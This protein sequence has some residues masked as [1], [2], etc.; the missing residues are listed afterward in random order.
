[1]NGA[2]L[3]AVPLEARRLAAAALSVWSQGDP[4]AFYESVGLAAGTEAESELQFATIADA[5]GWYASPGVAD[6][7]TDLACS[8]FDSL[9]E[10]AAA[11]LAPV[12]APEKV[13]DDE[14]AIAVALSTAPNVSRVWADGSPE[15]PT[16]GMRVQATGAERD[17]WFVEI[18]H[19]V[20][21]GHVQVN[22]YRLR[23]EPVAVRIVR[24][25]RVRR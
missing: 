15:L 8:V 20:D 4:D 19:R 18:D 25:V 2:D 23:L 24:H 16:A 10:R 6:R 11:D 22:R 3:A 17:E 1:M 7:V 14:R 9:V 5:E 21:D 13:V 12:V